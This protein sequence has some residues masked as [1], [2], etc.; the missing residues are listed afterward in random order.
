MHPPDIQLV[1]HVYWFCHLLVT[2]LSYTWDEL[3][4]LDIDHLSR[5]S[6]QMHN[7]RIIAMNDVIF[8]F[9]LD[10][11]TVGDMKDSMR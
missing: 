7:E 10:M 5:G 9:I 2:D 3:D 8:I 11:Y 6:F 4:L 1:S